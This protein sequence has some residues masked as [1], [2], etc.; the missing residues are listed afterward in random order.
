M[1]TLS[2]R[3]ASGVIDYTSGA[4]FTHRARSTGRLSDIMLSFMLARCAAAHVVPVSI[5]PGFYNR[6]RRESEGEREGFNTLEAEEAPIR[7]LLSYIQYTARAREKLRAAYM[8]VA[9]SSD[10]LQ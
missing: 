8:R 4:A 3:G 9:S 6:T 2:G 10:R 1:L 7:K 5:M